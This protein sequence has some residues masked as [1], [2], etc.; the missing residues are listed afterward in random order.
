MNLVKI[1]KKNNLMVKQH[2]NHID[3]FKTGSAP[4]KQIGE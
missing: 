1:I 3:Q 4:L 2:T